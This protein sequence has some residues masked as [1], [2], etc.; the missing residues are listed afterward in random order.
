MIRGDEPKWAE[1]IK[2]NT[3]ENEELRAL[4]NCIG[5]EATKKLMIYYAGKSIIIPKSINTKYK[6][7][8]IKANYDGTKSSRRK[9]GREC[10]ISEAYIYKLV[11]KYEGE[12]V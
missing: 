10:D 6:C 3:I 8:Y 1:F 4:V 2:E 9:L 7:R 5:F 12:D 11:N